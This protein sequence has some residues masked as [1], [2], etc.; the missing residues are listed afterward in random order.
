MSIIA[1][2]FKSFLGEPHEHNEESGQMSFDCPSCA[3]MGKGHGKHKLSVNYIKNKYRCWVCGHDN[4]MHGD[5][6]NLIKRYGTKSNLKDYELVNPNA[7]YRKKDINL[8]PTKVKLPKEFIK[9]TNSNSD[10]P[11][12]NDAYIYLKRRGINDD[13]IKNYNLGYCYK[14]KYAFRIIFPSY[15]E[16][17]DLNFFVGR[18]WASFKSPKYLNPT[19]EKQLIIFNEHKIEWD[20]TIYLVEG[21]F[22]HL[23][24]PNSIPLLGKNISQKLRDLLYN[25]AK[26]KIIILLDEDALNDSKRLYKELN[27]GVLH[28]MIRV[29]TPPYNHDPSSIFKSMGNKGIIQLVKTSRR[30]KEYELY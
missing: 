21:S 29:C 3:E 9:L 15:D 22:D 17:G 1:N 5:V 23:V 8:I 27:I 16:F 6:P 18:A 2:I 20:S 12:F 10:K 19:A 13:M 14:G 7:F 28:N 25:K 30:F 26:G 4:N 11:Y 24:I